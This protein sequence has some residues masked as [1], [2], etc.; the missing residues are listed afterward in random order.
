MWSGWWSEEVK[1]EGVFEEP[2]H[3]LPASETSRSAS[4]VRD[5]EDETQWQE[6][7]LNEEMQN[8]E[9]DEDKQVSCYAAF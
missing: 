5:H 4:V 9:K 7:F 6:N 3:L 8:M 2:E 1:G